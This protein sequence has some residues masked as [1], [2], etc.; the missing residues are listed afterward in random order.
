MKQQVKAGKY[1][2]NNERMNKMEYIT[3][4]QSPI[5][6]ILLAADETRLTGLWFDGAKYFA[7]CP[8]SEHKEE[9]TPVLEQ[10]GR[11]FSFPYGKSSSRYPTEKLSLT[12][13]SQ[14]K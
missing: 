7:G 3:H 9:N 13:K 6:S 14:K 12:G 1:L 4:Y 10:T 8:A 11:P 2:N 5:G